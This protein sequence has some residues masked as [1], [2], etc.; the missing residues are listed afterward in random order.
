MSSRATNLRDGTIEIL[1]N[2]G[3]RLIL[4]PD[5]ART[6]HSEI[7]NN[8]L[9][10]YSDDQTDFENRIPIVANDMTFSLEEAEQLSARLENLL[11]HE[12]RGPEQRID[13]LRVGY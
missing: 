7:E 5:E 11:S 3:D 1:T 2:D 6:F 9:Q 8:L 12:G 10:I 4:S 13:W